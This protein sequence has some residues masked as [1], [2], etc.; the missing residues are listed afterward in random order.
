MLKK[1]LLVD[2]DPDECYLFREILADINPAIACYYAS[3]GKDALEK[4]NSKEIMLP[5]LI[6]VDINIPIMDGWEFLRALQVL[7][8]Y[9]KIPIIVYSTSSRPEDKDRAR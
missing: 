9:K 8:D 6:F 2:V 5:D 4:L 1:L 7:D 3:D